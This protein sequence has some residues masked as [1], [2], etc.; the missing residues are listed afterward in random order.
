MHVLLVNKTHELYYRTVKLSK[1]GNISHLTVCKRIRILLKL[2]YNLIF[3]NDSY[4][5]ENIEIYFS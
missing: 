1:C 3:Q 4:L 5:R 2:L